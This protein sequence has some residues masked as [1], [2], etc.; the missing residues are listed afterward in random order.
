[1]TRRSAVWVAEN[2]ATL[3]ST[4]PAA[5]AQSM[6]ST[7]RIVAALP[8]RDTTQIAPFGLDP[9]GERASRWAPGRRSNRPPGGR[10]RFRAPGRRMSCPRFAR[11]ARPRTP[12]RPPRARRAP[13]HATRADAEL[14]EPRGRVD[15]FHRAIVLHGAVASTAARLRP[16]LADVRLR[17]AAPADAAAV[18]ARHRS[19][20]RRWGRTGPRP[21][22]RARRRAA[23]LPHRGVHRD[24]SGLLATTR[25][26]RPRPAS[27]RGDDPPFAGMHEA[28]AA[29]AGGSIDAMEAILRGDVVHAFHPGGGLHH[30]MPDRASGFCVYDDPALAIARARAAGLRVLYVDL[31]TH[32]GDGVQAI[33]CRDPGVL[34]FS[35][36]ESGRYL[37][38]GTGSVDEL[39]GGA[40]PGRRSTCRSSRSP[41]R[42]PGSRQSRRSSRRSPRRSGPTSS[43]ASTAPIPM[44]GIRSPTCG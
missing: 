1:M 2:E 30:A 40:R 28:A 35:I 20:S 24:R 8:L 27:R 22:A 3:L 9:P 7:S 16:A 39:G 36:H 13:R 34:T 12:G 5:S 43:S 17:A 38:P 4:R 37:F 44:P 25:S 41:A 10:R 26:A 21:R 23:R 32:H 15:A 14:V 19:P 29:V 33:H 18:R 42:T 11:P 31:D 6:T